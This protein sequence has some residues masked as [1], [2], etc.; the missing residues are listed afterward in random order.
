MSAKVKTAVKAV[1]KATKKVPPPGRRMSKA[2][3]REYVFSKHAATME[4]LAK[5]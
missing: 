3:A 1:K 5:D 4:L 2:E